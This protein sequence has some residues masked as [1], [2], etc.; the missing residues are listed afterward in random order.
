[1]GDRISIEYRKIDE[2]IPYANNPRKN[3]KAV[4]AVAESI[5]EFGFK[6]PIIVDG[7]GEVIAGHTRIKAAKK[8]GIGE[9]PCV[10]ADDLTEQQIKAFRLADNKTSELADWDNDLLAEELSGIFDLDMELFGFDL[11]ED[12]EKIQPE[13]E[14]TEELREEHNYIVLYFDNDVDWL[15][16]QSIFDIHQVQGLSTRKDK[17]VSQ[18]YKRMGIGRVINGA[19]AIERLLGNE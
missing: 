19:K 15:Q 7:H 8:L 10:L 11:S 4:D 1:M 12:D 2:L 17:Q 13:V 14:F 6:V 18:S 16:A 9:V 3:D 5:K